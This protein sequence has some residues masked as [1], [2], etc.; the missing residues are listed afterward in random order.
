MVPMQYV[1][2]ESSYYKIIK[3]ITNVKKNKIQ[4]TYKY[5]KF[6]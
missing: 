3:C 4:C 6:N 5:I 2:Q 1:E